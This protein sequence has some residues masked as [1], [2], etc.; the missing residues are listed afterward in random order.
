MVDENVKEGI[1]VLLKENDL[2]QALGD[3][4][5]DVADE[6]MA[7]FTSELDATFLYS[8]FIRRCNEQFQ[9]WWSVWQKNTLSST[10]LSIISTQITISYLR[11]QP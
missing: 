11:L 7:D 3:A 2:D 9:L 5:Q 4:V 8:C 10:A 6:I 1:N